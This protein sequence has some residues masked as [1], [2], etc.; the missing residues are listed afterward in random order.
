MAPVSI[1]STE[2]T[3]AI[4]GDTWRWDRTVDGYTPAGGWSLTYAI[5]G[6]STLTLTGVAN[7]GNTGWEIT[8]TAAQTGPVAPG[9]YEWAAFV[10]QGAE[11]YT[12]LTG[13]L[14]VT[15]NLSIAKAGERQ[16]HEE[17]MLAAIEA[18]LE[19]R[20]E[21]DMEEYQ[22]EGRLVKR[23]PFEQLQSARARYAFAVRLQRN[24]G[25][26]PQTEVTF[27]RP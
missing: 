17:R 2:P 1:P 20:L 8:A 4:A 15:P 23:I 12:V 25:R 9:V 14:T 21:A 24:G 3:R 7:A 18:R 13:S 5:R 10:T 19:G 6:K 26:T 27:A 16:S 11:R 22:L